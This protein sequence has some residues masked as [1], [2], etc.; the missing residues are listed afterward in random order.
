M[1]EEKGVRKYGFCFLGY[2]RTTILKGVE[3]KRVRKD[4]TLFI[5]S[6][7]KEFSGYDMV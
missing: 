1:S 2:D 3:H 7:M 6:Q 5:L 4:E